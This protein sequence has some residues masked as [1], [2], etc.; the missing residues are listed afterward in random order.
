MKRN[1]QLFLHDIL[2]NIKDIENFS[3]DM[4]AEKLERDKLKYKAIVRSLEIIGE[5]VKNISPSFREKYPE[6]R[7]KEIAGL[8]DILTHGYFVVD[9][10]LVWKII[11]E[12]LPI[13]KKQIQKIK[14]ELEAKM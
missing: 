7:W 11:R 4:N 2:D 12:D 1:L 5:A 8:R 14:Q 9:T 13:L 10:G 6:T 3:K